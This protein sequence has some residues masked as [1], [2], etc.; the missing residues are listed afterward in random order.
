MQSFNTRELFSLYAVQPELAFCS[1]HRL[2]A[3]ERIVIALAD[4]IDHLPDPFRHGGIVVVKCS[5][6]VPAGIAARARLA[7]AAAW[8]ATF[9]AVNPVGRHLF[10]RGHGAPSP[11]PA[12]DG[13]SCLVSLNSPSIMSS[14]I[15]RKCRPKLWR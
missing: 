4:G 1:R 14:E 12:N 2:L 9:A 6:P 15:W 3:Q 8:T 7:G 11:G 10:R 13:A 5:K